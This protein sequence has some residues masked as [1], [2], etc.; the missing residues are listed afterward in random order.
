VAIIVGSDGGAPITLDRAA[1]GRP[2]VLC[3]QRVAAGVVAVEIS[4]RIGSEE[5][6]GTYQVAV[7]IDVGEFESEPNGPSTALEDLTRLNGE[8]RGFIGDVGDVDAYLLRVIPVIEGLGH[9]EIEVDPP[10]G[11]D[12]DLELLDDGGGQVALA[13]RSGRGEAEAIEVDLPAGL[14][15]AGSAVQDR[16][17]SPLCG[18]AG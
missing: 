9:A 7:R 16:V 3:G 12:V 13:Q 10:S 4:G 8:M 2:E 15:G 5:G 18:P 17:A 6:F 1:A 14:R 11:I